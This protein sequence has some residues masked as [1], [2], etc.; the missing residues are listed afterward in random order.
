M[1]PPL[2]MEE[3]SSSLM[4]SSHSSFVGSVSMGRR[5]KNLVLYF[6]NVSQITLSLYA[7][8]AAQKAKR[9]NEGKTAGTARR[10]YPGIYLH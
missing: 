2:C 3:S 8:S 5:F 9:I 10:I 6:L 4:T 7:F 1:L